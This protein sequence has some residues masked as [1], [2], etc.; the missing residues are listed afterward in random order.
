MKR[1]TFW[2]RWLRPSGGS[3]ASRA[4]APAN[5]GLLTG[6][7]SLDEHS[8]QILLE[9]IAEVTSTMDLGAVLG[10]IVEKSLVVTQA[11]RAI[12]FLGSTPDE[13]AVQLARD[14]DGA[15]LGRDLVYSKS[16]VRRVM[17]EGAPLRSVVQSDR[18]A[19][20][21]GQ[22]VFDLKLRA[23][24]CAPLVARER[25]VGAIYVDSRAARREFSPR[26]LA[27]FGALSAQ[28][29]I[30]IVNAQLYADSIEKVRLEKDVEVVHRIQQHLLAPLPEARL[31]P[32]IDLAL[33]AIP[34]EQASGDS[35]D[36]LM[37]P[38]G[39]LA[40]VLG[41]ARGHGIGPALVAHAVQ[42]ALRSYLEL[43][44]DPVAI[45]CRMNNRLVHGVESGNFLSLFLA[46]IDPAAR[47]LHYVNAGQL[48]PLLVR[49]DGAVETLDKTGMVLG[50]VEDAPYQ[51][52]GP[53]PFP[54]GSVLLVRT[55]GVDET[56]DAA[57]DVFGEP[58]LREL[59]VSRR[60]EPAAALLTAIEEALAQFRGGR[61]PEDDLTMIL[62]RSSPT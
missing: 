49:P 39:R 18:E 19:L 58:R 27:L 48:P 3:S 20:E 50:V 25:L 23:V 21:L 46:L 11:E 28:L 60:G 12:L 14:R 26:D 55:D 35:Y 45:V 54:P 37:L 43:L 13:L 17:T 1:F 29:A 51:V 8:L 30:A 15:D 47:T 36:L 2:R 4:G 44:D 32:G 31:R 61:A 53:I 10:N 38:S 6:D 34:A 22:S 40:L 7:A 62:A 33:C 5:D 16:I 42:A 24:M 9:S 41:D 52:R 59:L 57:R 56:R